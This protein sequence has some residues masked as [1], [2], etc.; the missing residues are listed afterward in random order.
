MIRRRY[1]ET[2]CEGYLDCEKCQGS[3]VRTDLPDYVLDLMADGDPALNCPAC[4][5]SGMVACRETGE[6]G[7][8]CLKCGDF[9]SERE[10]E[11]IPEWDK[12]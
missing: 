1:I 10:F 5:G 7:C 12:P 9:F 3:G 11:D 2:A 4:A 8:Q 6:P